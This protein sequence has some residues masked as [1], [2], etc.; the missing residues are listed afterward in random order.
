MRFLLRGVSRLQVDMLQRG[1]FWSRLGLTFFYT[2]E[3][4]IYSL[5]PQGFLTRRQK[6]VG[7][8]FAALGKLIVGEYREV[9]PR[10]MGPQAR[11]PY[12]GPYL[13]R[14]RLLEDRFS[15]YF[16]LFLSNQPGPEEKLHHQVRDL[17]HK[18]RPA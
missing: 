11:G 6:A 4:V 7:P 5:R 18:G 10:L 13:G 16:L 1:G 15:P 3:V 2:V 14:L 12:L 9:A 17:L 8:N